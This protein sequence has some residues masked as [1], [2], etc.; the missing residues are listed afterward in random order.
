[1]AK[2][3]QISTTIDKDLLDWIDK[4]VERKVF[5]NRSHGIEACIARVKEREKELFPV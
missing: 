3:V 2:K 4:M 5:A 1:M